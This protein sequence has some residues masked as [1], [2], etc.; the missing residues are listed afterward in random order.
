M[1]LV[2]ALQLMLFPLSQRILIFAFFV[3]SEINT[4]LL[5]AAATT[6][7]VRAR[8]LERLI[9]LLFLITQL[10]GFHA[11]LYFTG[12]L[13]IALPALASSPALYNY[14]H[15]SGMIVFLGLFGTLLLG[16]LS[17]RFSSA[18]NQMQIVEDDGKALPPEI[19]QSRERIAANDGGGGSTLSER[20]IQEWGERLHHLMSIEKIYQDSEMDLNRLAASMGV[21]PWRLSIFLNSQLGQSFWDLVTSYRVNEVARRLREEDRSITVLRI[22]YEAGFDSKSAFNRAFRKV[23]GMTPSEYRNRPNAGD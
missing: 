4:S 21:Q 11:G 16:S 18:Y 2:F 19:A 17:A 9:A 3:T 12:A 23:M 15:F 7:I 6:V 8:P 13:D 1:A 10:L 20:E 22:A 5:I 14:M